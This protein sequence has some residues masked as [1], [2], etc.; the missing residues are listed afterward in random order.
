MIFSGV[1]ETSSLT[2]GVFF[3]TLVKFGAEFKPFFCFNNLDSFHIFR[4]IQSVPEQRERVLLPGTNKKQGWDTDRRQ[5][6]TDATVLNGLC[7]H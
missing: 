5:G 6:G 4:Y 3:F 7:N 2:D 1:L